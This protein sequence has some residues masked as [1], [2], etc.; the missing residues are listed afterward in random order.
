MGWLKKL[1]PY[2][3]ILAIVYPIV[4]TLL[5]AHGVVLPDLGDIGSVGAQVGGTALLATSDK[6]AKK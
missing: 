1:K 3:G 6:I 2:L 5:V 4:Q